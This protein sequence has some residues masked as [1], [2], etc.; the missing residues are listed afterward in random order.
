MTYLFVVSHVDDAE[1]SCA[2]LI[3]KLKTRG[4][5]V[6]VISLS[7]V[8]GGVDL[9]DEFTA[10]MTT[11]EVEFQ[12]YNIETRRFNA[13]VNHIN[14]LIYDKVKGYDFVITHDPLDRHDDHRILAEQV[15]RVYNGNLFTF[16]APHNGNEDPNYFVELTEEQLEKKIAALACYKSQAHRPYMDPEFIRSWAR[17]NGIKCGKLYAEGFKVVRL[18]Q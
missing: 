5:H 18:V 1:I 10:S 15:R 13:N 3:S 7:S 8:Y 4:D 16:I 12:A 11:L 14:K 6:K 9:L 2:G 17:Y